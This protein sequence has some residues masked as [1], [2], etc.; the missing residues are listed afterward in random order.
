MTDAAGCIAATPQDM[1]LYVQMI[2]SHGAGPK[3]RVISENGFALF[4]KRH[5][6]AEEFGPTASYGYGIAVDS[7]DEHTILRH[8]GGMV[9]FASALQVDI[10]E[11]VGAFA[12]I[13][14]MQGYR[15]NPVAQHAIQLMRAVR[16][17]KTLPAPPPLKS[18]TDAEN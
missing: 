2:A 5:I 3:N 1:G 11:G 8:T 9:S 17:R 14:A 15:P 18:A 6:K 10:D 4:S 16:A 7:L 13:N 12:S